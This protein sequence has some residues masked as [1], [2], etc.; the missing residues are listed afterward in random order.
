MLVQRQAPAFLPPRTATGAP[1]VD[2]LAVLCLLLDGTG[3]ITWANETATRLL[4][5]VCAPQVTAA[6]L[7]NLVHRDD[8]QGVETLLRHAREGR[9]RVESVVR[10]ADTDDHG[11]QRH[12]HLV[13]S[14]HPGTGR[15]YE[16][17]GAEMIVQGWDVSPL[18]LRMRELEF[19]AH[20]D[21]LTGLANR[22]ALMDRLRHEIA[23]SA[24]S[25]QEVAVMFAD[26]DGMKAV[27]D[28]YGHEAGDD[29]LVG[30]ARRLGGS[31]RPGD[32]LARLGGDEFAVICPDLVD[33]EHAMTVADR[34]RAAATEPVRVRGGRVCVTLSIG[35]AFTSGAERADPAVT[36]L[37]LADEAMYD[38]RLRRSPRPA[39]RG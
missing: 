12:A 33:R 38:V 17:A 9:A 18:I 29:V 20:C 6:T 28:G 32:T 22:A 19:H 15:G 3:A 27:N 36:L 39:R 1:A 31:L 4:R 21:P 25:G 11:D 23:R 26:V 16:R 2:E 7:M 24:R 13:L 8:H 5:E 37:R 35:V 34:L 10:L 30:L 14:P